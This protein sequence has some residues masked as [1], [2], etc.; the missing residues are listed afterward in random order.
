MI[1]LLLTVNYNRTREKHFF[2]DLKLNFAF[3][4][5]T[6][7]HDDDLLRPADGHGGFAELGPG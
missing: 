2:N 3:L 6:V 1:Q 4:F 5:L 7:N